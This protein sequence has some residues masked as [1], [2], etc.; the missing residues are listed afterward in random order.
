VRRCND[1]L[2]EGASVLDLGNAP[3]SAG[4]LLPSGLFFVAEHR[5]W[6]DLRNLQL[7]KMLT[8]RFRSVSSCQAMSVEGL[9]PP[10]YSLKCWPLAGSWNISDLG[11]S[12]YVANSERG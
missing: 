8:D 11:D 7:S 9:L 2:S 3:S 10:F 1:R 12:V 4:F 5:F 6:L